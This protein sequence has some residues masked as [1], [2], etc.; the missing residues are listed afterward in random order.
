MRLSFL[1]SSFVVLA[2]T[3]PAVAQDKPKE[4]KVESVLKVKEPK[5]AVST[6]LKK[7]IDAENAMIDPLADVDKESI[8]ILRNKYSIMRAVHVVKEDIGVAV[9]SCGSNNP[10]MK[11]EMDDRFS[12][13]K[14]AVDPILNTAKKQLDKDIENQTIVDKKQFKEVLKLNDAAYDDGESK[15]TKKPVSSKEACEG[16]IDSMDRTE[17]DM[18]ELL[19]ETLLPESVIRKRGEEKKKAKAA[20]EKKS[21]S[22]NNPKPAEEKPAEKPAEPKTP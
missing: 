3:A 6:P 11:K 13:W 15:V 8:F 14:S 22:K 17:D 18:I 2:L 1:L 12:Q 19:Q 4:E 7:W 9:K 21:F 16:L 10:D 5:K 20:A